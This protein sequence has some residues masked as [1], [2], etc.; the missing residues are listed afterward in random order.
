MLRP[1][2]HAV[3]RADELPE[4]GDYRA[5]ELVREPILLVR[6]STRRLR[7]FSRIC[8][9]RASPFV[10]GEG[11]TRRFTCPYHRWGYDLQGQVC[12]APL[13]EGVE[14]FDRDRL[15]RPEL[16]LEEGQGCVFA[17]LDPK[18]QPLAPQVSGL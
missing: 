10:E 18:P 16:A 14:G 7:A 2:W 5:L 4:V 11:N 8:L 6:D 13:M 9:H 17:S 12:A 15:R 1:G 3:A